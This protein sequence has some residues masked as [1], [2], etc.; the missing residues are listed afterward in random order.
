MNYT[1]D[2]CPVEP[3]EILIYAGGG[4]AGRRVIVDDIWYSS[5]TMR[6]RVENKPSVGKPNPIWS[7]SKPFR[8]PLAY[9]E[10]GTLRKLDAK[11]VPTRETC[12]RCGMVANIDPAF[13]EE[14]YGHRPA[15]R[16]DGQLFEFNPGSNLFDV[17]V[18]E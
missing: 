18:P 12:V 7:R 9:F 10:N 15:V 1:I 5:G 8:L 17:E 13:H 3:G 14:R 11:P 2:N 6:L 16:R 4:Y